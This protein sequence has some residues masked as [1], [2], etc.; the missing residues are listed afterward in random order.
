MVGQR[1]TTRGR[2]LCG[3]SLAAVLLL[4][5]GP[6]L[7]QTAPADE[8]VS[9]VVVT[10]TSIKGVPPTGSN[11]ISVSRDDIETLGAANTPDL[12]ASVP[13]LNS[14][15]TAPSASL[16]GFGSFAPGMR[17]L[18]ANATLPLM[19]G[20]RLV[21]AAANETNP[22][23][24]L[25]PN[26]AI[27]RI[28]V[29]ADGASSIYGSDAVAGVVNFITRRNVK[30]VEVSAS[31]GVG[32]EYYIGHFGGLF[33][34]SWGSGSILAAYQ[35]TEND[36]IT[37]GDR[38][39]RLQDFRP[40]GGIDT[41]GVNCPDANVLVN[42]TFY[43]V[44]YAAPALA[45][46]T[47]NF[48]DNTAVA[49]LLPKSRIHSLFVSGHQDVTDR[50]TLW[51]EVLYSDRKD[52]LRASPP[53][54][55]VFLTAANPFFR[56][57]AG[58][59]ATV[60]YVMF[61]P[62]NL[63][64]DDHFLN[65]DKRLVGNSSFG[66]D[67]S[68]PGDFDLTVYGTYD[69]AQNDAFIPQIN[70]GALAAAAAG[71]TTATALD[72][73]GTGT[74]P[75]VRAAI[76]NSSTSVTIDQR[77]SL[78][79]VRLSG[80]LFDLPGGQLKVAVGGE[81]RRETF[82]QTGF[83]GATAV[84]ED[85][86]RDISSIYG[87]VFVPVVGESNRIP[88]LYSLSLSLSGRYDDYSDFGS[89]SNPKVGVNWEP[90]EGLAF[91]ASYGQS[92]R[93]PGMRQIGATVGAYYLDAASAAVSANDPTRGGAQ[94]N[95]VYLL[96]GNRDLQPEEATTYSYGVSWNPAFLPDLRLSM[97]YYNIEYTDVIGTPSASLVFTDPTFA[98][99]VYRN[100]TAGQ[101]SSLLS[102]AVPVNLPTPLP[103]IGNILDLRLNNF[104]SRKT[105]GLDFDI[106]YRW[107]TSFG[108]VYA[109]LAGNYVLKFDT[110]L[111]PASPVVDSLRL[112]VPR[113]TARATFGIE[114][115]P[116]S[117]AGFVNYR[118]GV[119]NNFT[120][121][122][123]VSSY[124]ADAYT[125]VDLRVSWRLGETGWRRGTTLALQV[126]DLFDQDPPFFPA[127]DGIGGAYNPIGR[128]V[129]LNLRK[130]F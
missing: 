114:A 89:T 57:P 61:R 4:A 22:D 41:R 17:G 110:Q 24:P 90:M 96:G 113:A 30:G 80:P 10:G 67:V 31:Y 15:N 86:D 129:G 72:P 107:P 126:N 53:V 118:D 2:A 51:G 93:A 130:S 122:T 5:A 45:A 121:P 13:Q 6:G 120:T 70:A 14:F 81:L 48:C 102:I 99:V 105:D 19:N 92:F 108:A 49:D 94:V 28:E 77:T 65:T 75:A 115:G 125:T 68:L 69:W 112:G 95:T 33:G 60:E 38:D 58:T 26:L 54:Q 52:E 84:P 44:Y 73:F 76:L 109:D 98:S 62:D 18:P 32:D 82:E 42:T 64:G 35:Y 87:E 71:T 8:E 40:Y 16:G 7:A 34:H 74:S 97:T 36:N 63:I 78:G 117:A 111:S 29:V 106:N 47:R 127:T 101:L 55:A 59:F 123:G 37:A 46:N 124:E 85:L 39:Y 43:S 91:R 23:Y 79:A 12:L 88:G 1:I 20:H 100:P 66:V 21:A 50:V 119:R 56:A 27:E 25:I 103:A 3:T 104:G 128:F 116:I 11:L 83:V 9:E